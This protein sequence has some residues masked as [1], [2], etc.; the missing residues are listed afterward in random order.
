MRSFLQFFI[1]PPDSS[2]LYTGNYDPVLVGLSVFV[3]ILA[4]YASLLVSHHVSTASAATARRMWITVGGLCLGIGIWAM[5]FVGM[6]AFSLPC[7]SS[8]DPAITALSTIPAIL[9]SILALKII[10]RRTL[11]HT[12]LATGGL[13][14]GAGIGAMHYSGMAAMRLNGL[15]RYDLKLFLLSILVAIV[16]ATL[17]LWIKF[18][19][20]SWQARWHSRV[21]ILSA[22]VM[23]L[24]VSGMHYTAMFAA[25]FVRDDGTTIDPGIAPAFL[26]AIVLTA[27]TLIIIVTLVATYVGRPGLLSFGRSYRLIGLLVV[28]WGAIAWLSADYYFR[29]IASNFYQQE[30]RLARQQ[31]ENLAGNINENIELLK[32][33]SLMVSRD[34][35]THQALRRFGANV[36]PSSLDYEER[37]QRWTQDKMLGELNDTLHVATTNLGANNIFII[38]A[39]GDCIA[40]GNAGKPGSPVGSNYADRMYFP[41]VQ[42]GQP[43]YQYAVGRT[44]NVPGLFYA[45]PVFEN[46]RFLGATVVK[47]DITHFANWT[48]QASAFISDANGVIA[49]APDKRLEFRTL[50]NASATKLSRE[51]KLLQYKR[52]ELEPLAIA[53]W[54]GDRFPSAVLIGGSNLP[55]TLASKALPEDAITIHVLRPLGELVRLDTER[56]WLFFLLATAGS[57]LIVAASAIV[58]YLRETKQAKEDLRIAATA[59]ESQEGMMVTDANNVILRVN[60]A[61]TDITGYTAEEAVGKTPSMLKSGRH[62]AAYYAELWESIQR[63]GTWQGE[64]WNRRKNGEVY[65]NWLTITVVKNEDGT[66]ANHIALLTDITERKAAEEQL[67]K[68]SLAVEQS[69]ESVVITDLDGNIEYVN[70]AFVRNTGYSREEA[71]GR[72]P[73]ILQ[74]GK[75]PPETYAALWDALSY[76]HVWEGEFHNRRKNG[77]DYIEHALITPI[78]QPDGRITHY[79][80]VKEDITE[81]KLMREELDRYRHHLEELVE[82]RTSQLAEARKVAETANR[83]KSAFLANMSHE[84][85]TPMN[86]IIGLTHLLRRSAPTPEQAERLGKVDA[87]ATHLLSIINDILDISKIEAGQLEIEHTDFTLQSILNHI[88]SL[89]ADQAKAKGLA[90][91]EDTDDVP[92]WLRGDPTR[93]RQALLNYVSNAIKFTEKG[94]ITLRSRLLEE[95]DGE[96]LV[97]FE[98]Q[99]TGIGI[100]PEKL[101]RLFQSFEQADVSTTRKYGGTGLGLAITRRLAQIMGGEAG[102]ESEIGKGSTFWFTTRLRRGHGIMPA[103]PAASADSAEEELHRNHAGARLLLAEDNAVNR[104]VAL[105]LLHGAGLDVDIAEDGR[106]AVDKARTTAYDII[107]MDMQMPEMDGLAATRAIRQMP[108]KAALPIL[109]MTANVFDEDRRSC[110]EAGMNDFVPKPVDPDLLYATLMKWLPARLAKT[111]HKTIGKPDQA[112]TSLRDTS[113][114]AALARLASVP[115]LNVDRGLAVLRGKAAKYLDLLSR[116][117]ESHADD[118]TRLAA[119]LAEDDPATAQ[120][121]AHTLKGSA[122]TLGAERLAKMAQGLEAR[123]RKPRDASIRNDEI[124]AEMEAIN[125]EIT[126]LA[127]ALPPLPVPPAPADTTP[128]DPEVLRRMLDELEALLALND[129]AAIALLADYSAPLRAALGLP[130]DELARRIRQFDFETAQELLHSLR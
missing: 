120:R 8:Y 43:G 103:A 44:T 5:H 121:L 26:A 54:G 75:T 71:I 34:K 82:S 52:A 62:D 33:I 10:S 130:F 41:Q 107:L 83:A 7:S 87:A 89:L 79:V 91:Q 64:I 72:N 76:G 94:S 50:P 102:A 81:K 97:R 11:S 98:V 15:I 57:M 112:A 59:F 129:A 86:A 40:A 29:D 58:L 104:E 24:A 51:K 49:L 6:L 25:Y 30:T 28:G 95:Q 80:A 78:H 36:T 45:Y 9:A 125:L 46:G 56:Y 99:D 32:G 4:S 110:L 39:A 3:A 42:A 47:R 55:K 63:S 70:E 67:R 100:A 90:I 61:F 31:A 1:S 127:A 116:F 17:A 20:Q 74:S 14:I 2:V 111:P 27:T 122:A 113:A 22:I 73:R 108:G 69:P 38:N 85:R 21:T 23:G 118:M 37:K 12:Q 96:I 68:L 123:L 88:R 48:N 35:E 66:I 119:S 124:C 65:A 77:S 117:V 53:P 126:A 13:L 18:R 114:E 109:A 106:Q 92:I 60:R 16:L 101:P 115:G 19:L 128:P 105:E 93:L 84:I